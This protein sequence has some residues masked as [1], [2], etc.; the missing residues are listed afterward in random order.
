MNCRGSLQTDKFILW[1]DAIGGFWVC[2][3]DKVMLGQPLPCAMADVPIL[4]DISGRHARISR[5]GESYVIEA[6]R[7]ARLN[8]RVLEEMGMLSDG[9]KIQLGEAVRM[10]FRRPHPL[11]STARLDFLSHHRTQPS[12]DA[13][14]LMAEACILGPK[15]RS[16]VVCGNWPGEVILYRQKNSLYCRAADGL[17]IDGVFYKER[18]PVTLNSRVKGNGFSLSLETVVQ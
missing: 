2:M 11:S 7:H 10:A 12:T 3:G 9:C 4:A 18:G 14:L 6:L 1:L 5:D 16:H 17:E 8:G 15:S 13:V